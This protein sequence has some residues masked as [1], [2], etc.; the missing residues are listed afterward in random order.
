MHFQLED[1]YEATTKPQDVVSLVMDGA[2]YYDVEPE[3]RLRRE[4]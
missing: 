1:Y 4:P 2:C 3:V